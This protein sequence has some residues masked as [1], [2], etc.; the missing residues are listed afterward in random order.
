MGESTCTASPLLSPV[1]RASPS[2]PGLGH[3][4]PREPWC[5]GFKASV[6]QGFKLKAPHANIRF[7]GLKAG[8]F[9]KPGSSLHR[10]PP[11]LVWSMPSPMC[12]DVVV[13]AQTT[14]VQVESTVAS[15]SQSNDETGCFQARV[16]LAPPYHD[17]AFDSKSSL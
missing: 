10:P 6:K 17:L 11:T 15:F 5:R 1:A 13:Q 2:S 9:Q 8:R 4:R 16:K 7:Q 14:R 12:H 3:I